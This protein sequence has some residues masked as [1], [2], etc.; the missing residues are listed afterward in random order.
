SLYAKH[1]DNFIHVALYIDKK[2]EYSDYEVIGT[3]SVEKQDKLINGCPV[4]MVIDTSGAYPGFGSLTYHLLMIELSGRNENALFI[5]DRENVTKDAE[6]IYNKLIASD[7][8]DS[9]A[10]NNEHDLF[11]S[12]INLNYELG[13]DHVLN[14]A[15][16]CRG[17]E[18]SSKYHKI[19]TDNHVSRNLSE[20]V[21][22]SIFEEAEY[23]GEWVE[24]NFDELIELRNNNFA[25]LKVFTVKEDS[26]EI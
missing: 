19:L 2:S 3:I 7:E 14:H 11:T 23:V 24:N 8:F 18:L 20:Q 15:Y 4:Y 6:Q 12:E 5:S 1:Y 21:K 16:A 25:N 22:E 17:N 9:V 13:D 26:L 10:I